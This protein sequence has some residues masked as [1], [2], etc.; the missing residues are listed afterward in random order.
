MITSAMACPPLAKFT[1]GEKLI[2]HIVENF[3]I[4]QNTLHTQEKLWKIILS[5]KFIILKI[6]IT[7][8]TDHK[9]FYGQDATVCF[10]S[11]YC[12]SLP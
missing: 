10:A 5:V 3:K 1:T 12:N 11:T 6:Y 8:L 4:N 2:K 9:K 7:L